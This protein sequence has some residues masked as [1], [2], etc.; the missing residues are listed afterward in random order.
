MYNYYMRGIVV[1]MKLIG[2]DLDGTLLNSNQEI[3]KNNVEALKQVPVDSMVFICSG[4]ETTDIMNILAEYDLEIP[5]IGLNGALGYDGERK[6]FDFFFNSETVVSV[7]KVLSGMPI[8]VYTDKESYE[9][10]GYY[11]H[12][13]DLFDEVGSEYEVEELNYELN[14]EKTITS[15]SFKNIDEL[16]NKGLKVYKFFVFIPNAEIK[17]NLVELLNEVEGVSVTESSAVNIEIVPENVSK[18]E[19]FGLLESIYNLENVTRI[20]IGDSLNDV[21]LFEESDYSFAMANSHE[22][23]KKI[24]THHTASND[25]DGVATVLEE[26]IHL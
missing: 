24:A 10:D 19:V 3:S 2:I 16:V 20:A 4:R 18:G 23:I 21:T 15:I 26:I 8:K 13:I 7:A 22:E 5:S 17:A 14:Y 9:T 6:L 25:E 1:I 12:L 11:Q